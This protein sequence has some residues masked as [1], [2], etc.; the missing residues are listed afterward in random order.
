VHGIGVAAA[1]GGEFAHGGYEQAGG[2]ALLALPVRCL[3]VGEDLQAGGVEE[4]P[5]VGDLRGLPSG[6]RE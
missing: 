5:V 4:R 3:V 2:L 1:F 6:W